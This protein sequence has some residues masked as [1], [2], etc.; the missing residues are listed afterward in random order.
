MTEEDLRDIYNDPYKTLKYL[1]RVKLKGM[2]IS[3]TKWQ[4]IIVLNY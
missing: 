1:A 4:K 3:I 2:Q